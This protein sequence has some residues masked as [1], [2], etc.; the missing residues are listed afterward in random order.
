M[1]TN[2]EL[3][4]EDKENNPNK[5]NAN[6]SEYMSDSDM[7]ED[8]EDENDKRDEDYDGLSSDDDSEES[9]ENVVSRNKALLKPNSEQPTNSQPNSITSNGTGGGRC[10]LLTPLGDQNEHSQLEIGDHYLVKRNDNQW[11]PAEIIQCR[12]IED[13]K[14]DEF[15]YYVHYDG[16]NR[17]LDEWVPRDRIMSSKQAGNSQSTPGTS[18]SVT[19]APVAVISENVTQANSTSENRKVTRNQKRKHDEINHVQKGIE[20]MDPTTAALER[21]IIQLNKDSVWINTN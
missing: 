15:E 3:E 10:G 14:Q 11:Y 9:E 1:V 2:K 20:E 18:A 17:R 13:T 7:E 12:L 21:V 19:I 6:P 8:D 16:Y 5:N 4:G